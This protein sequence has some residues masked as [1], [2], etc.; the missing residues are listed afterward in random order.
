MDK[1]RERGLKFDIASIAATAKH[2][3][4]ESSVTTLRCCGERPLFLVNKLSLDLLQSQ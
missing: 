2:V 4:T 1:E 3:L